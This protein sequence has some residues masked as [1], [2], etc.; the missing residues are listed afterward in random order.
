MKKGW[1]S[2]RAMKEGLLDGTLS[3]FTEERAR[4]GPSKPG[5]LLLRLD[6]RDISRVEAQLFRQP[7]TGGCYACSLDAAPPMSAPIA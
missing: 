7:T 3:V 2:N 1:L 5:A 4:G 6:F